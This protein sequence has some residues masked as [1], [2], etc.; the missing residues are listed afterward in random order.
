MLVFSFSFI[1]AIR[2]NNE[3]TSFKDHTRISI[4]RITIKGRALEFD[5]QNHFAYV[6]LQEE[7][8]T[9]YD[10]EELYLKSYL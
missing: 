6:T 4:T 9:F 10:T 2:A 3:L 7:Y 5:Q 1:E 8:S